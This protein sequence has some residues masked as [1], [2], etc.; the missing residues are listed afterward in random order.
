MRLLFR[1]VK[2]LL[3]VVVVVEGMEGLR[4]EGWR[5]RWLV[6]W[7]LGRVRLGILPG[8]TRHQ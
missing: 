6:R 8:P 5:A 3:G 1:G 2:V 4:K 7:L